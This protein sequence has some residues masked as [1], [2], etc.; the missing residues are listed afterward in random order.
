MHRNRLYTRTV[1]QCSDFRILPHKYVREIYSHLLKSATNT[2]LQIL[3]T[4]ICHAIENN[5]RDELHRLI[6]QYLSGDKNAGVMQWV[7]HAYKM[8]CVSCI[9]MIRSCE[10][11]VSQS[12]CKQCARADLPIL[13]ENQDRFRSVSCGLFDSQLRSYHHEVLGFGIIGTSQFDVYN[14][15]YRDFCMGIISNM[16]IKRY[17]T[18]NEQG[19]YVF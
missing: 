4:A 8:N 11:I 2:S 18:F 6:H 1:N 5:N 7:D 13:Q 3:N 12:I 9:P 10:R 15:P 17:I 16:N 19:N 14:T